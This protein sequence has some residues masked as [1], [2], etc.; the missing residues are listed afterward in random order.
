MENKYFRLPDDS[1]LLRD[2]VN[3]EKVEDFRL[4]D[5]SDLLRDD[6]NTEKVESFRLPDDSDL[7]RSDNKSC[8]VFEDGKISD[9]LLTVVSG[10]KYEPVC[11]LGVLMGSGIMIVTLDQLRIMVDSG[12]NI[13]SAN[14]INAESGLVEIEYQEY[15]YDKELMDRRGRF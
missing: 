10:K 8:T 15:K 6:V 3:T 1:D 12:C 9:Y 5:D 4:P 2:D 14:V 7:L 11:E 13:V